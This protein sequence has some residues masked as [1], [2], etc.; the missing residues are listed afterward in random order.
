M[1]VI[2]IIFTTGVCLPAALLLE[3]NVAGINEAVN[4]IGEDYAWFFRYL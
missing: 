3:D 1:R 4:E 2:Q